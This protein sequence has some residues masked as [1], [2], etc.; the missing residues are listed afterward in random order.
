MEQLYGI[1]MGKTIQQYYSALYR[2]TSQGG[3]AVKR[4]NATK[5]ERQI[6]ILQLK[7]S[8]VSIPP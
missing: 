5:T 6:L 8:K 1:C 3:Y 7:L 2:G 4:E